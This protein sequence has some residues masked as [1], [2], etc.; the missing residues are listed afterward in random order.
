MPNLRHE[1]FYYHEACDFVAA[2]EFFAEL[3]SQKKAG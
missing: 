3:C 1:L 2:S